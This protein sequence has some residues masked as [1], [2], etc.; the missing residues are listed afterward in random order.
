MQQLLEQIEAGVRL[1]EVHVHDQGVV[2]A[3][4]V[5]DL[6]DGVG[7]LARARHAVPQ[8]LGHADHRAPHAL[9]V[10][11]D[12][13][14]ER[15][16]RGPDAG[17]G[18]GARHGWLGGQLHHEARAAAVEVLDPHPP[19]HRFHDPEADRE[20]QPRSVV[21][22][23]REEGLEHPIQ[24]CRGNAG[25]RILDRHHHVAP[26]ALR[27]DGDAAGAPRDLDRLHGVDHRVEEHLL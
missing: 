1:V 25:A 5:L 20:A 19:A 10:L 21:A 27:G 24:D 6:A 8:P 4:R 3:P 9:L 26:G 14:R 23:R 13:H 18:G 7:E 11:D 2:A 12:Q 15:A 17:C 16:G 22:F